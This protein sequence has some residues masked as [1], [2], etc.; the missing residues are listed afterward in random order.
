MGRN[1]ENGGLGRCGLQ[2]WVLAILA[3]AVVTGCQSRT[4][5]GPST[6]GSPTYQGTFSTAAGENGVVTITVPSAT[7]APPL[8]S[9]ATRAEGSFGTAS[10]TVSITG[11][12]TFVGT[13]TVNLTGT[14]D[15]STGTFSMAGGGYTFT[16]TLSNANVSGTYTGSNGRGTWAALPA[17]AT[18]P[19]VVVSGTYAG[20]ATCGG[21]PERPAEFQVLQ[22][23]T[24]F[25]GPFISLAGDAN[26]PQVETGTVS[27]TI[28]G[29]AF[30]F[31]TNQTG[32]CSATFSGSGTLSNGGASW[33][34]TV[35]GGGNACTNNMVISATF[36]A[37]RVAPV[38]TVT[39]A[40]LT[41][42]VTGP[43]FTVQLT[44]TTTDVTGYGVDGRVVTWATSN[45]AVATVSSV[46]L[47]TGVA[48]A[49]S[50]SRRRAKGRAA[51]PRSLS[52]RD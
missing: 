38:A 7:P 10:S 20:T 16:G 51:R 37:N 22:T 4:S 21:C 34:G 27:G 3:V 44:A 48:G 40:P 52:S 23:G 28:N 17:G 5:T 41:A 12:L 35:T 49:P 11:T 50:R 9:S 39:V 33:S 42:T 2:R 31:T 43:S 29:S 32:P 25:S 13:P 1:V 46:G 14:F 26:P 18:P 8:T 30:T 36:Q 24:A 45:S 19:A 47:V 6:A 15:P